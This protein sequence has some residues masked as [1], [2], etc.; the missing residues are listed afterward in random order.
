[1]RGIEE[2]R[3][4]GANQEDTQNRGGEADGSAALKHSAELMTAALLGKQHIKDLYRRGP[5]G[6]LGDEA[7]SG[8]IPHLNDR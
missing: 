3:R 6:E 2:A 8:R 5:K 7:R 4:V 1:L